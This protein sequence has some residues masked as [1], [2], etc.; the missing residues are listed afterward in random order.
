MHNRTVTRRL[1]TAARSLTVLGLALLVTALAPSHAMAGGLTLGFNSDPALVNPTTPGNDYLIARGLDDGAQ[2]VRV[3]VWW[4]SVA[5]LRRPRRFQAGNPAAAGYRWSPVDALVQGLASR[6]LQVMINIT[7]A[8]RWAEGRHRPRNARPGTWEPDPGQF[9]LFA[10]AAARRYDGRFPYP[11]HR[12]LRLPRVRYWQAWNEPNLQ[13]Y[14]APQWTRTRHRVLATSPDVYRQ[15]LNGFYGAIKAISRSNIVVSAGMAPYGNPWGVSVPGIGYRMPPV[16]F[17]RLLFSRPA[18]CDVVAQHAYPYG[19]PLWHARGQGDIAVPDLY[20]IAHLVH[21]ASR[22]GKL[23][24]RGPKQLWVTELNW[25][26]NPPDTSGVS[27]D[28]QARWYEQ[29]LYELWRQGVNTVLLLQAIDPDLGPWEGGV[30]FGSGQPK[31]AATAFQFPF[32]T[33]RSKS[34]TVV[35]WGRAPVAGQL[36]LERLAGSRWKTLATLRVGTRQVFL[37]RLG[38]RGRA[39]LR[40]RVGDQTSLTWTQ[41]G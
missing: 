11:G 28:T 5:P 35:A 31:P 7:Y 8:P 19:G 6:G 41:P 20:K 10:R 27:L 29:A 9:A 39:V 30:Y 26:S 13:Y 14:L 37:R 21:A 24:P 40:A 36:T 33:A 12:G 22:A 2:I 4:S 23:L 15:M 16:T 18:W 32:V 25:N 34:R 17:D 3:N 38:L 1:P